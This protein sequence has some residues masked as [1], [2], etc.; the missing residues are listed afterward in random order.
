MKLWKDRVE[1]ME[2]NRCEQDRNLLSI[3]KDG[4]ELLSMADID[5]FGRPITDVPVKRVRPTT[6]SCR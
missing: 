5:E 2:S 6:L 3:V 4:L 1:K